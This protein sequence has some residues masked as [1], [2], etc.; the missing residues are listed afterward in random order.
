MKLIIHNVDVEDIVYVREVLVDMVAMQ[1]SKCGYRFNDG[2]E[3]FA[4]KNK[5]GY[6]I[7]KDHSAH[8]EGKN[9]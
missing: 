2:S 9:G 8:E 1:R 4:Q 3:Y 7:F 6:S 5:S